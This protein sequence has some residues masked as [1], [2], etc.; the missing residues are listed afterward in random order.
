MVTKAVEITSYNFQSSDTL[1]LDTNIWLLVY[2]PQNPKDSRIATYSEGFKKILAAKSRIYIDVL[3]VSEFIN[4]YITIKKRVL[5][6]S[7]KP[8][9]FRKENI[10]KPIAQNIAA[11]AKRVLEH[12]TRIGNGFESLAIETL[13][14]EYKAGNSDFNDQVLAALCKKEGLTMVTDDADL[15]GCGI[16][17]LTAN[18]RLLD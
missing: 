4:R 11:D 5:S 10:F 6:P 14:N 15:K 1:L 8:K 9:E 12:C 3:I 13:L 18:K 16:P 7:S 2:G 17:I